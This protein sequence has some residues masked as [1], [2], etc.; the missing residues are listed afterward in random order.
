MS[1]RAS[2]WVM[3]FSITRLKN[4]ICSF[5]SGDPGAESGGTPSSD[6]LLVEVLCLRF[7]L[8]EFC[9]CS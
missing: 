9:P 8:R 4:G 7:P 6:S 2:P 1:W 3:T 5:R